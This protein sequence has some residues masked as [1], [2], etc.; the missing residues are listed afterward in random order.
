MADSD[1]TSR[2][3]RLKPLGIT[4]T[5]SDCENGLHCYRQT[6]KMRKSGVRGVCRECGAGLVDWERLGRKDLSD[7][8][9][10]FAALQTELIRHHFWHAELDL[11]AKN[12]ARRKGRTVMR[13]AAQQR[14]LSS[15]ADPNHP[16][17]GRQTPFHGNALYYAQHAVAACCRACIEEWY[18]IPRNRH[19][20]DNEVHYLSELVWKYVDLRIPDLTDKGEKIPPVRSHSVA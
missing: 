15:V 19:L 9:Y 10:I 1:N 5:S 20:T 6:K 14:I 11:K 7:T 4:C 2:T 8:D 12:H 16:R 17:Q 3:D 13:T 18:A